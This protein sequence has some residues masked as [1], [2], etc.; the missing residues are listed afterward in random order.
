MVENDRFDHLYSV[1]GRIKFGETAEEAVVREVF[2]ETGR[3]MEID[4]LGF[5]HENFFPGDSLKK[6]GN[7][8]HEISFFFYMN[9]PTDFE[10]YVI[11]L[12]RME[13]RSVWYGSEPTIKRNITLNFL[14][15][16]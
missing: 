11:V 5:I 7:I 6:Q 12:Q 4:R 13:T 14:K 16:N 10:Q 15:Q 1:G 9:V 3:K 2:E 8:V